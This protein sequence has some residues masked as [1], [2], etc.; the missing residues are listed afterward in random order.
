MKFLADE[1]VDGHDVLYVAENIGG[2][3]DDEVLELANQTER[4]LMTRDKDFGELVYREKKV[5]T[6]IILN[7]LYEISSLQKAALV[8]KVIQNFGE[9]LIGSF[10]VIQPGRIRMRKM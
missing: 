4:I 7:R 8:S 9:Q 6:G 2:T 3:S 10:T 5:H 1:G